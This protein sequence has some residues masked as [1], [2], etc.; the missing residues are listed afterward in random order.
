[1]KILLFIFVL[2]FFSCSDIEYIRT[3]Y[4]CSCEQKTQVADFVKS[5]IPANNMVDEE[6]EDVILTLEITAVRIYCSRRPIYFYKE[7]FCNGCVNNIN[8]KKTEE[9]GTKLDSCFSYHYY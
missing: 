5:S 3:P 4:A 7:S 2:S 8:F 9:L 6:M 1:M